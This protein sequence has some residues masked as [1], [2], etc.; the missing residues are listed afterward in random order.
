MMYRKT[1]VWS[2]LSVTVRS[3]LVTLL[4]VHLIKHRAIVLQLCLSSEINTEVQLGMYFLLE[5]VY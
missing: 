2:G 4:M 1:Y 5:W 3:S